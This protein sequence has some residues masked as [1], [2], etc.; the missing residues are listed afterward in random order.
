V[1]FDKTK[2]GNR[3]SIYQHQTKEKT[4]ILTPTTVAGDGRLP[5]EI[6]NEIFFNI[7]IL[8]N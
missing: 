1:H 7:E 4:V 6:L 5:P 8:K 2:Y 3:L